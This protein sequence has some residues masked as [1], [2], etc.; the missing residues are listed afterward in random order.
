MAGTLRG[1][2]GADPG[3]TFVVRVE[4]ADR[5]AGVM[6]D[7]PV[8][9]RLSRR[10]DPASVSMQT[11]EVR[12]PSGCVPAH[13]ELSPDGLVLILRPRRLLTPDVEHEVRATGLRDDGGREVAAHRSRFLTCRLSTR[14]LA[15]AS[16]DREGIS[17][18]KSLA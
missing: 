4:P 13:V 1:G 16:V 14:D 5:S 11:V 6:R 17:D 15:D 3:P 7:S 9:L 10:V 12:D 8:L 18:L 2:P